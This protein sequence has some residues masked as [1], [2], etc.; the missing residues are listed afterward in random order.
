MTATLTPPGVRIGTMI[1]QARKDAG[2]SQMELAEKLD[3][4]QATISSWESLADW[5]AKRP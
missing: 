3:V 1:A 2:L 5:L 4:N